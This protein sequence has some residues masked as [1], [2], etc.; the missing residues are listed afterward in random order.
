MGFPGPPECLLIY[1][2]SSASI[3]LDFAHLFNPETVHG[4]SQTRYFTLIAKHYIPC[5][6]EKEVGKKDSPSRQRAP[7]EQEQKQEWD[8]AEGFSDEPDK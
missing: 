5:Q 4:N 8:P 3:I 6:Q 7:C 1:K 2:G